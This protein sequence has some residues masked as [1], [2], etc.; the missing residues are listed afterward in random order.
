MR[1]L[2]KILKMIKPESLARARKRVRT[3][4]NIAAND[5]IF[6]NIFNQG[7]SGYKRDANVYF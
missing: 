3:S 2:L 5:M 7:T 6:S 1:Y 4:L